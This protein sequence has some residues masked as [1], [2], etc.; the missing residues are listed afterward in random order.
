MDLNPTFGREELLETL[1]QQS[2]SRTSSHNHRSQQQPQQPHRR[3]EETTSSSSSDPPSDPSQTP[4]SSSSL[5]PPPPQ[6]RSSSSSS[7]EHQR[8]QQRAARIQQQQRAAVLQQ[9]Q[10]QN[11]DDAVRRLGYRLSIQAHG[12]DYHNH[13]PNQTTTTSSSGS[14]GGGGGGSYHQYHTVTSAT[15]SGTAAAGSSGGGGGTTTDGTPSGSGTGSSSASQTIHA[16]NLP[17]P[18]VF[19]YHPQFSC[20]DV[21]PSVNHPS[22]TTETE[23][24]TTHHLENDTHNGPSA[25]DTQP[26]RTMK[27]A[28]MDYHDQGDKEVFATSVVPSSKS[29]LRKLTMECKDW[30]QHWEIEQVQKRREQQQQQQQQQQ[31]LLLQQ[32]QQ[33]QFSS[34]T[35]P[36]LSPHRFAFSQMNIAETI[37]RTSALMGG[38]ANDNTTIPI[39]P[40]HPP[41]QHP[42]QPPY[43]PR[44]TSHVSGTLNELMAAAAAAEPSHLPTHHDTTTTSSA[45]GMI[46]KGLLSSV[47]EGHSD[48][49]TSASTRQPTL[50]HHQ[51]QQQNSAKRHVI[52]N[53]NNNTNNNNNNPLQDQTSQGSQSIST[54]D[55][56]D[57]GSHNN[58]APLLHSSSTKRSSSKNKIGY[59]NNNNNTI[60]AAPA[61]TSSSNKARWLEEQQKQL[62]PRG[63]CLTVPSEPVSNNGYDNIEGNYIAYE[64]DSISV[65]RKH[66]RTI[67]NNN[68]NNNTDKSLLTTT[69]KDSKGGGPSQPTPPHD[70]IRSA[71][72]RILSSAGQGTFA[73]VFHCV[74]IQ[75]GKNVAVKIVKNKPA[76]TRQAAIEIDI[77]QALQEPS[78]QPQ[79]PPTSD[80]ETT[81]PTKKKDYMVN[82]ISYFIHENHL[83][84]VFE[85]LGLN[86]YEVLKRRQFRGLSLTMVRDIIRQSVEGILELS[87]KNIVHCDLK[88]ENIL[89]VSNDIITYVDE[90]NKVRKQQQENRSKSTPPVPSTEHSRNSPPITTST[91]TIIPDDTI[92]NT[93]TNPNCQIKLID[94]GSACFE[95]HTAHSYIQ[96]RFYRCPEVLL[97]LPYDTAIDM[98]SLGC[99]AAELFVGLPI[100][101]GVHEHDQLVRITEMIAKIP[102][103]MLDQGAKSTKYYMKYVPRPSSETTVPTQLSHA[104]LPMTTTRPPSPSVVSTPHWRLKSQQEFIESLSNS[105]I[106]KK[107]GMEKLQK[108]PGNRYFKRTKLSDI[109]A[110]H[111]RSSTGADRDLVPAFT[112][113]LYSILDPD[114]WK[115]L[116]AF[117]AVQHPFIT[118]EVHTLRSKTDDIEVNVKE[119]NQANLMLDTFWPSPWDPAI[120]RRKLL[121]VQKIREKQQAA[122]RTMGGRQYGSFKSQA[123]APSQRSSSAQQIPVNRDEH[124]SGQDNPHVRQNAEPRAIRSSSPPNQISSSDSTS[125]SQQIMYATHDRAESSNTNLQFQNG[126]H[127]T[128]RVDNQG[129]SQSQHMLSQSY[130]AL[131]QTPTHAD[132][133]MALE[134]PGVVPGTY[135]FGGLAS[136]QSTNASYQQNAA[137]PTADNQFMS[138]NSYSMPQ[139]GY[140]SMTESFGSMGYNQMP[141]A[142]NTPSSH[143]PPPPRDQARVIPNAPGQLPV[144]SMN[145]NSI[146]PNQPFVDAQQF[147]LFQQQQQQ[148]AILQQQQQMGMLSS[149]F[150]QQQQQQHPQ[151][152]MQTQ[153]LQ[154]TQFMMQPQ[155]PVMMAAAP[156]GGFYYV[157]TSPT[158]QPI[159]LQPVGTLNQPEMYNPTGMNMNQ[160]GGPQQQMLQQQQM[161]MQQQAVH[162]S[163]HQPALPPQMNVG[164]F[165]DPSLAQMNYGPTT[166]MQPQQYQQQPPHQQQ[167]QYSSRSTRNVPRQSRRSGT[168]M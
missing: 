30:F 43:H 24:S 130:Q 28:K 80:T 70:R 85:L 155:Q 116:T 4:Q 11:V 157:M 12:G 145:P 114:P 2:G 121:N 79:P 48:S 83:C 107:G 5:Q 129:L 149:Q 87:R 95:G 103:W 66:I 22:S 45:T 117:Q 104:S 141:S 27:V 71:T 29:I 44:M 59:N 120:C 6:H 58:N 148:L 75:S 77:F 33:Q 127:D 49:A 19:Q 136:S 47:M 125:A 167:Q 7:T 42:S 62:Y 142:P 89:F 112:H 3:T 140:P 86:L 150:Q 96:S 158:G 138:Y 8:R 36:T 32:Q 152:P 9:Q 118:G 168:S 110:L 88:P 60:M 18:V 92:P 156:N 16:Q 98:W 126:A 65:S 35:N 67:R 105:E 165:F 53:N 93:A 56:K 94:F 108:Q 128:L 69:T 1:S 109:L 100:L 82:L 41:H 99:V 37:H 13:H 146:T 78:K 15:G 40:F 119:E 38:E 101:P 10:Q 61:S 72:Y 124:S 26:Y 133:A 154:P 25:T 39:L 147:A 162:P 68:H 34:D 46:P 122:R 50:L 151:I 91:S 97:G 163:Q 17:L 137:T 55:T 102:D 84:L 132:F 123:L 166:P 81:A 64:N 131:G 159:I 143:L 21:V 14:G 164:G 160:F 113:F 57:T 63:K 76:Y 74:H 51:Q 115:R 144:T 20:F 135:G 161:F 52:G 31:R 106:H 23:T 134:R 73:Q 111:G 139:S 153:Q 90:G 54:K